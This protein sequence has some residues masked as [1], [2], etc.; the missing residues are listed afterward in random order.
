MMTAIVGNRGAHVAVLVVVGI[1]KSV[2]AIM[3]DRDLMPM[4]IRLCDILRAISA[5][6]VGCK[7]L[8]RQPE[9]K[10]SKDKM[11]CTGHSAA[12]VIRLQV[13]L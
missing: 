3:R 6:Q 4:R 8:Q 12:E 13:I 7:R 11:T 10:E 2:I 9:H 5:R 1:R